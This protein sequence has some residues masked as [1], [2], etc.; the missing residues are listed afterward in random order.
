MTKNDL[1]IWLPSTRTTFRATSVSP[2]N[3]NILDVHTFILAVLQRLSKKKTKTNKVTM[4]AKTFNCINYIFSY[5][6]HLVND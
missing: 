5:F 6:I 2:P 1:L 3:I 4:E